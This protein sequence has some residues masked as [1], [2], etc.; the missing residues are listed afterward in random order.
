[1]SP[2]PPPASTAT[3]SAISNAEQSFFFETPEYTSNVTNNRGRTNRGGVIHVKGGPTDPSTKH[4]WMKDLIHVENAASTF[5]TLGF[6]YYSFTA[7]SSREAWEAAYPSAPIFAE[8]NPPPPPPPPSNPTPSRATPQQGGASTDDFTGYSTP[9]H[10][11]PPP[12][13]SDPTTDLLRQLIQEVMNNKQPNQHQQTPPVPAPITPPPMPEYIADTPELSTLYLEQLAEFKLHPYFD[14]VN[15]GD[16]ENE[17]NSP[18][19]RHVRSELLRT[20]ANSPIIYTFLG[21]PQYTTNGILML[22]DLIEKLNPSQPEHLLAAVLELTAAE[23]G[24]EDGQRFMCRLRGL[25]ARLK[26]LTIDKFFTLLAVAGLSPDDYPGIRARFQAGDTTITD[27]SIYELSQQVEFEDRRREIA[28]V[29]NDA[30]A[31]PT[32]AARRAAGSEDQKG[33]YPPKPIKWSAVRDALKLTNTFC[34]ICFHRDHAAWHLKHG[35]PALASAGFVLVK[36]EEKST[37][38]IAKFKEYKNGPQEQA[39]DADENST[40]QS[41]PASRRA[42]I[43]TA[44]AQKASSVKGGNLKTPEDETVTSP[45][46]DAKQSPSKTIVSDTF[47]PQ[48]KSPPET[49]VQPAARK[50]RYIDNEIDEVDSDYDDDIDFR[51]ELIGYGDPIP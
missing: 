47:Y 6:N 4:Y 27:A 2:P 35:C 38:I 10:S 50:A 31:P 20:L 49:G 36:D 41:N 46:S 26:G 37:A 21:Q 3:R 7:Y 43:R 44:S 48:M 19:S 29:N 42:A 25:Y 14:Q 15:W 1:M 28:G 8:F 22:Q 24:D 32:T 30:P 51:Q 17:G 33:S 12:S 23:Q 13:P 34:P 39:D 40:A 5:L 45:A 18:A 9:S 16:A 11:N